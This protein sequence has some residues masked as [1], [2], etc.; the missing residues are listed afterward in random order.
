MKL[1]GLLQGIDKK[2]VVGE[3]DREVLGLS[4]DSRTLQRG[5]IFFALSGQH[6]DGNRYLKEVVSKGAG[7]IV[8]EL[9]PPPVPYAVSTTWIQVEDVHRAM[10]IISGHYYKKPSEHLCLVGVTGTNGKT[11]T[12]YYLESILEL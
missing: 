6:T 12:S 8:S 11:T 4:Y 10:S 9:D 3:I 1:A 5:F 7:A 2:C